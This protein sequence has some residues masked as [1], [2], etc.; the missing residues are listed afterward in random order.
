EHQEYA[1]QGHRYTEQHAERLTQRLEQGCTHHEDQDEGDGHHAVDLLLLVGV[2]GPGLPILDRVAGRQHGRPDHRLAHHVAHLG[3]AAELV[4]DVACVLLILA[5][6]T[7]EHVPLPA[8]SD[9]V[10][11]NGAAARFRDQERAQSLHVHVAVPLQLHR[12][13]HLLAAHA[14]RALLRLT[15]HGGT[16]V[17]H[18]VTRSEVVERKPGAIDV[19]HELRCAVAL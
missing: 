1:D 17:L 8:S 10:E 12:E 9:I 7:R 11:A 6:D 15:R 13:L 4:A 3:G 5:H 16:H 19:E 18:D 2:P 14:D